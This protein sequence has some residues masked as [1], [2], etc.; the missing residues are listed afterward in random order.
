MTARSV[1][2]VALTAAV[3]LTG[4]HGPKPAVAGYELR[5]PQQPGDPYILL[6]TVKNRGSGAG[7]A[8]VQ[9][10][11]RSPGSDIAVATGQE[12]VDL[13]GRETAQV[14]IELRPGA[15]GPYTAEVAVVYPP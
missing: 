15:P 10:V 4:C 8:S 1:I 14:A 6:V 5:D 2:V 9:A 3:L 11:L 12:L 13:T 7:E